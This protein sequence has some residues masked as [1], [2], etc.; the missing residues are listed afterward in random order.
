MDKIYLMSINL[1]S[2]VK[3]TVEWLIMHIGMQ[4]FVHLKIYY[5]A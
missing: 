2:Y 3:D 1:F 5:A 4:V